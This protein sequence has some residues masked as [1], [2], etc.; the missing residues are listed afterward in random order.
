[1][2]SGDARGATA[3]VSWLYWLLYISGAVACVQ[4]LACSP[5]LNTNDSSSSGSWTCFMTGDQREPCQCQTTPV[6]G[7]HEIVDHCGP[8]SV[9]TDAGVAAADA[10]CCKEWLWL[11]GKRVSAYYCSCY[12]AGVRACNAAIGDEL[13]DSCP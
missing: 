6:G 1:M 13:V 12:A 11:D 10:A 5:S 3:R 2:K 9:Q 7:K 8:E 4:W